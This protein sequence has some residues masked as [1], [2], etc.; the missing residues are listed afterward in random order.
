MQRAYCDGS[1]PAGLAK[2]PTR[3][4]SVPENEATCRG[5]LPEWRI[6]PHS[7]IVGLQCHQTMT[8][9][10]M[11]FGAMCREKKP[12]MAEVAGRAI[13]AETMRCNKACEV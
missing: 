3:R 12:E 11:P 2:L 7:A 4:A 1:P 8:V 10:T 9:A 6:N 13:V 5:R